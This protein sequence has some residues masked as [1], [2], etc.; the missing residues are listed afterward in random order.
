[1]TPHPRIIRSNDEC[2]CPR[3]GKCWGMDDETPDCIDRRQ[4]GLT[5]IAEIRE[6]FKLQKRGK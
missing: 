4:V 6:R 5:R 1:M 3:C 2:Q